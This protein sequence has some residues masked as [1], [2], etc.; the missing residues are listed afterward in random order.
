MAQR[1]SELT[2][3][4]IFE[5]LN[6]AR[7][8]YVLY[9][10]RRVDG[11]PVELTELARHIAAWENETTVEGLTQQQEKRVY[12]SL[13]QSHIPKLDTA[14]VVSY[15][16]DEGLVSIEDEAS[17]IDGYLSSDTG[18]VPWQYLYLGAAAVSIVALTLTALDIA[19]FAAVSV[20]VVAFVMMAAFVVI[21]VAHY[22]ERQRERERVLE[23][24]GRR[25]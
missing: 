7:R 2:Q 20:V 23:E 16:R 18:S 21:A 19:V 5:I 15:D 13:Y 22:I 4:E 11:G 12:V 9:Y 24:L 1:E 3:D 14:G 25:E 6:S 10:L 8:R 17:V